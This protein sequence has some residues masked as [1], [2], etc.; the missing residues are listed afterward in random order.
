MKYLGFTFFYTEI[1]YTI[2][3]V[4][5][6]CKGIKNDSLVTTTSAVTKLVGQFTLKT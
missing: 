4:P 5:L 6:T 3:T 1:Q 2:G